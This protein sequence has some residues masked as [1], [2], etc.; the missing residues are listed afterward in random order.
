MKLEKDET[1]ILSEMEFRTELV[2]F[3]SFDCNNF[4][5]EEKI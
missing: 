1:R 5:K 2:N 4:E 3:T